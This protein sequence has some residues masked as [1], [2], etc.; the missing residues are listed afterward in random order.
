MYSYTTQCYNFIFVGFFLSC[1]YI[2]ELWINQ[3]FLSEQV[4]SQIRSHF[5]ISLPTFQPIR[6]RWRKYGME[7]ILNYF[8]ECD[9]TTMS[10]FAFTNTANKLQM[11]KWQKSYFSKLMKSRNMNTIKNN[12]AALNILITLWWTDP[13][14]LLHDHVICLIISDGSNITTGQGHRLWYR[15]EIKTC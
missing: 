14:H 3:Y 5:I 9:T 2:C 1:G 12:F 13:R 8:H 6:S 7:R 4:C 15:L 10:T 11:S